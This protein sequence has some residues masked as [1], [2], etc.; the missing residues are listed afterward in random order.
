MK[1]FGTF[2][3]SLKKKNIKAVVTCLNVDKA[4]KDIGNLKA[5]ISYIASNLNIVDTYIIEDIVF[6]ENEPIGTNYMLYR[7]RILL[8]NRSG[9]KR[10]SYSEEERDSLNTIRYRGENTL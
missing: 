3:K 2:S 1:C 8:R 9:Y 4:F 6:T 5:F 10:K 7:F